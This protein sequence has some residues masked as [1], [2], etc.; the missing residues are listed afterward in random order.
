[1]RTR[2]FLS[3]RDVNT[4][5]RSG[6]GG[7][8]GDEYFSFQTRP[9]DWRGFGREF[10]ASRKRNLRVESTNSIRSADRRHH[11]TAIFAF[12][13]LLFRLPVTV[14]MCGGGGRA[15]SPL[16]SHERVPLSTTD[17]VDFRARRF[18]TASHPSLPVEL[19]GVRFRADESFPSRELFARTF[20][21]L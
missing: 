11:T 4:V 12:S 15:L 2:V 6:G 10:G 16:K 14:C 3:T 18:D 17:T 7:G 1:M 20:R 5:K 13:F 21:S 19:K 9:N 8:G